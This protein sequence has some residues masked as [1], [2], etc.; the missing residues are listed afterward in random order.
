MLYLEYNV[1]A[2]ET[3]LNNL[4]PALH[5]P[6]TDVTTPSGEQLGLGW[7]ISP[8]PGSTIQYISKNGGVPAFSARIY[9]AP[10]TVTGVVVLTNSSHEKDIDPIVDIGTIALQVLQIINGLMPT[11][12]G[13]TGDQD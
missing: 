10:A 13:P 12:A 8:L 4:L 7:F 2:L 3:A 1:G 11:A 5:K 9:F 6:Y